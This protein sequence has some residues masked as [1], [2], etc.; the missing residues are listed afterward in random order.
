M[1]ALFTIIMFTLDRMRTVLL[2]LSLI[3]LLKAVL[4]LFAPIAG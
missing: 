2:A 3:I 1:A 4:V